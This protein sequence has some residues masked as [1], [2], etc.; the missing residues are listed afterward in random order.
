[1]P[2]IAQLNKDFLKAVF[3]DEKRLLFKNEVRFIT[4]SHFEEISVRRLWTELKN[5]QQFAMFFPD[6]YP[7]NKFPPREYFYNILN[8]VYPEYL[9]EIYKNAQK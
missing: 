2:P 9:S 6:V 4:I 1:M 7:E 5:D 8:S 3:E